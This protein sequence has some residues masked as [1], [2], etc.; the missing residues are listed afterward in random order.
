MFDPIC[1]TT[2]KGF[3]STDLLSKK[4]NG[5]EPER[6]RSGRQEGK[7]GRYLSNEAHDRPG[8]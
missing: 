3:T 1:A 7:G 2:A 8:D 5:N 6:K 4:V